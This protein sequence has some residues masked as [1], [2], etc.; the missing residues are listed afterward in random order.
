[1]DADILWQTA[2]A[3]AR[4]SRDVSPKPRAL[5]PLLF[6]TDPERIKAPWEIVARL[7]KGACV[8]YRAF[9]RPDALETGR[10]IAEACRLK[11]VKLLVGRDEALAAALKADGLHLPERDMARAKDLR[12][13][14]PDWIL[15]CALHAPLEG[16]SCAGLDAFVVSP[17][18]PAGGASALNPDL[19]TAAFEAIVGAL[20][21]P[22]YALGGITPAN[23]S[24]LFETSACGIA[25]VD[26]IAKA[27]VDEA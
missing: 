20:P 11:D 4:R 22:A 21:L 17:V 2:L 1:M 7:P 18:F 23:A 6:F 26:A 15:T 25:A 8:V 10:K 5:P 24:A 13:A 16:R 19:G 3:L 14:H 9:S 27:Y 12:S